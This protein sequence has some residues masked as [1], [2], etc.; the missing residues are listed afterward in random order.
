VNRLNSFKIRGGYYQIGTSDGIRTTTYQIPSSGSL[1]YHAGVEVE[2][3]IETGIYDFYQCTGSTPALV[4]SVATDT[5][6]GKQCWISSEGLLRFGS[7]GTNSTGGYI[8]PAGRRIRIANIFL[9]NCTVA[10]R[11]NNALPNAALT[12]RYKFNTSGG[13]VVDID[14]CVCPW[15][16]VLSHY[17]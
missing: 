12:T 10:A 7:D 6:R 5:L 13:G 1:Q 11:S 9:A 17:D 16:L 15:Y 4:T 14:K 8:V 3:G 2:T